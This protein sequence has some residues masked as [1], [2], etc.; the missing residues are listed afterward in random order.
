VIRAYE[1]WA[2]CARTANK[3]LFL[4]Y[5]EKRCPRSQVR[6]AQLNSVY[7]AQWFD[8]CDESFPDA[9]EGRACSGKISI[10]MLPDY[11]TDIDWGLRLTCEGPAA[12]TSGRGRAAEWTTEVAR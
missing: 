4:A 10:I 8:P 3:D 9:G 11:P 7:R 2:Y 5:F 12:P 6:S 1:G